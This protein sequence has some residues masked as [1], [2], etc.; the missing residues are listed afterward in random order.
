[1]LPAFPS[2]KALLFAERPIEGSP[3]AVDLTVRVSLPRVA[4][5]HARIVARSQFVLQSRPEFLSH[6]VVRGVAGD[7]VHLV[8][9]LAAVVEFFGGAL[10]EARF[11]LLWEVA[12]GLRPQHEVLERSVIQVTMRGLVRGDEF[13]AT[14]RPP[15]RLEIADVQVVVRADCPHGIRGSI[16]PT[17][18]VP[19]HR[20]QDVVARGVEETIPL[21]FEQ[22]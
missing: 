15:I 7:V 16:G 6:L 11:E 13:R 3:E 14:R 17:P 5:F 18:S 20:G 12:T 10:S 2:C 8:G 1:M 21:G 19:F 9:I 22:R 4:P